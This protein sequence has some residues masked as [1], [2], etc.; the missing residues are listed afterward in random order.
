MPLTFFL[1]WA[2]FRRPLSTSRPQRS[3]IR[4]TQ[5]SRRA[6]PSAARAWTESGK[7]RCLANLSGTSSRPQLE[8]PVRVFDLICGNLFARWE[9]SSKLDLNFEAFFVTL[10]SRWADLIFRNEAVVG[11]FRAT[12]AAI[13]F[14]CFAAKNVCEAETVLSCFLHSECLRNKALS[15]ILSCDFHL[16]VWQ[17]LLVLHQVYSYYCLYVYC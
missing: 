8:S 6:W 15:K 1:E 10:L 17:A 11:F 9:L 7:R 5:S 3:S 2:N 14:F 16:L 12:A 4:T 13:L